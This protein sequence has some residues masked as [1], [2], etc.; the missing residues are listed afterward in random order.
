MEVQGPASPKTSS[1]KHND[2][3]R[4]SA[5]FDRRMTCLTYLVDKEP[6]LEPSGVLF[7]YVMEKRQAL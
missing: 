1:E 6:E 4:G 2:C 7:P 5:H 3:A